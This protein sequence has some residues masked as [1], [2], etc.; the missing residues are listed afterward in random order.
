MGEEDFQPFDRWLF[1]K[2][3]VMLVWV[4]CTRGG[5]GTSFSK[6]AGAV[7]L[8]R[9]FDTGGAITMS[10]YCFIT[11]NPIS[12]PG[13]VDS[14]VVLVVLKDLNKDNNNNKRHHFVTLLIW[15]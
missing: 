5:I 11:L 1:G 3:L 6:K 10:G 12:P 8:E 13:G 2:Q 14:L 9:A 7:L 4:T 15:L